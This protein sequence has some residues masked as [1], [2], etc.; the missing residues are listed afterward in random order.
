MIDYI[1]SLSFGLENLEGIT[2]FNPLFPK[3]LSD[4]LLDFNF[5][6]I[7]SSDIKLYI[8][9]KIKTFFNPNEFFF[10]MY[11]SNFEIKVD[12]LNKLYKFLLLIEV[13][14]TV[15]DELIYLVILLLEQS[16]KLKKG[17][18]EPS[19]NQ[20]ERITNFTQ[21]FFLVS[22]YFD[23]ISISHLKYKRKE[24]D[25]STKH[26]VKHNFNKLYSN[27]IKLIREEILEHFT[28]IFEE[29]TNKK[30]QS[31]YNSKVQ[32]FLNPAFF[33]KLY[34]KEIRQK[35]PKS[36]ESLSK[37]NMKI[38]QNISYSDEF[39]TSIDHSTNL[40]KT[41][42]SPIILK[43]PSGKEMKFTYHVRSE[44]TYPTKKN[45]DSIY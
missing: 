25:E 23:E 36:K 5:F 3:I 10:I 19:D 29:L 45:S 35:T 26:Y 44:S 20:L 17:E 32:N 38:I 8:L 24:N 27:E 31:V 41:S 9:M 13:D 1:I 2:F 28:K 12:T 15:N 33:L 22:G 39:S 43:N 4:L 11:E 14:K 6:K 40:S 21:E 7:I 16:L 37:I 34:N 42:K 30:N 18:I